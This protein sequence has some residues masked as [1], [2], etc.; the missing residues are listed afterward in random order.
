M[1]SRRFARGIECTSVYID[2]L[3][4]SKPRRPRKESNTVN[5]NSTVGADTGVLPPKRKRTK[6]DHTPERPAL[7][8]ST[9]RS[10]GTDVEVAGG[11]ISTY[12]I[13]ESSQTASVRA[14]LDGVPGQEGLVDSLHL[15]AQ[16][17]PS[18]S[19]TSIATSAYQTYSTSTPAER[20]NG[21][22][23]FLLFP[24]PV[25]TLELGYTDLASIEGCKLGDGDIWEEVDGKVWA[26]EPSEA[27][28]SLDHGG[29]YDL[30]EQ[31]LE[32]FFTI[33]HPRYPCGELETFRS[34]FQSPNTHPEGPLSHSLLAVAL[35]Y[36]AR[37]SD[38]PVIVRDR[39]ECSSR[40]SD[41]GARGRKR[42]RLIALA[43]IRAREVA[44]A[45]KAFRLPS[46]EHVQALLML[47]GL[48]G[49]AASPQRRYHAI[50]SSTAAEHL[51]TMGCN[52][53]E[54]LLQIKDEKKRNEAV[55]TWWALVFS[56][57]FRSVFHR[58][59]PCLQDD[60]YDILPDSASTEISHVDIFPLIPDGKTQSSVV[61]ST[62]SCFAS[63]HAAATICRALCNSLWIP[64]TSQTGIPLATLRNFIHQASKYRDDFVSRLGVPT[65]WPE[66]WDFIQSM[67]SSATDSFWHCLWLIVDRAIGEFGVIEE[68]GRTGAGWSG[69]ELESIKRRISEESEH[70]AL[71]ITALAAVF[72]E[73]GY[74]RLDPLMC[75]HPVYEAGLYLARRGR[76]ECLACV[77]GLKQYSVT[78]PSLWEE[79]EELKRLYE[80]SKPQPQL[81]ADPFVPP[82]PTVPNG[83]QSSTQAGDHIAS[84]N[85]ND[86]S[87]LSSHT[88]RSTPSSNDPVQTRP[89]TPPWYS[90]FHRPDEN[91]YIREQAVLQHAS[92]QSANNTNTPLSSGDPQTIVDN[93]NPQVGP[94]A[95]NQEVH[96]RLGTP[97]YFS[98]L[99]RP[100]DTH[101]YVRNGSVSEHN[102]DI[103][104]TTPTPEMNSIMGHGM[105]ERPALV[106][107][108]QMPPLGADLRGTA[109]GREESDI[110]T[111]N[112][113]SWY[114]PYA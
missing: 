76:V 99:M 3:A 78:F 91:P 14:G 81:A 27:H 54:T 98:H 19:A 101:P 59:R 53:S 100:D 61:D 37:F 73:A 96:G 69:V 43:V 77:A 84:E 8:H 89:S 48:L 47:E 102:D 62:K 16:L 52:R 79:A 68:K 104:T 10:E 64:R 2:S 39:E 60:D 93:N 50:Y 112:E 41:I 45:T 56:D 12:D 94:A 67:T 23:R 87:V 113:F 70:A 26:E 108:T 72:T 83:V 106:P 13:G 66:K 4:Q 22:V 95:P 1:T 46:L 82:I 63:A 34:R 103:V 18:Q 20:Q 57:G 92:S 30:A 71:R 110:T 11:A 88:V 5:E 40:D 32:T 86:Q 36:G 28:L 9:S 75:H 49:R 114:H 6:S 7:E 44:E 74:M 109:G 85:D 42:S 24:H 17:A 38:H 33:C 31:L 58:L 35:A 21:L 55:S 65:K 97:P 90:L 29:V 111:G 80:A 15:L 105:P 51:I 107:T 25:T